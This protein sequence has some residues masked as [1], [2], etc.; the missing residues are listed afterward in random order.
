MMTLDSQDA[1][2]ISYFWF[3]CAVFENNVQQKNKVQEVRVRFT[4]V[5]NGGLFDFMV[6]LKYT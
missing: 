2:G 4:S 3:Q 5:I 1:L 6:Y